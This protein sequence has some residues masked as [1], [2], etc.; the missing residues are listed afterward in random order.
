MPYIEGGDLSVHLRKRSVFWETEV[1]FFAAQ[2]ILALN[3]LHSKGIIYQDL[4]PA[5]VLL[6][7]NGYIKLTDFGAAKYSYQTQK[8]KTFIGTLDFI[9]PE[10]LKRQPYSKSVDWWSLGILIYQL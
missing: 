7:T 6:E 5:N 2:I 1:K 3:F 9:A 10:V 4:K 8:Y